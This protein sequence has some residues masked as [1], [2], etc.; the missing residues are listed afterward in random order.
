MK[1]AV[2][3]K[4]I[5]SP[6]ELRFD[7]QL[8]RIVRE[9]V[10]LEPNSLDMVALGAALAL[11]AEV[12]GE[13]VAVSMGPPSARDV[14]KAA[15]M[16]GADA[17]W[18]ISD[19]ALAGSDTLATAHALADALRPGGFDLVLLGR[20]SLDAET[21]QV[22]PMIA[23]LLGWSV[24][25]AVSSVAVA[26]GGLH[27]QRAVEDGQEE[28]DCALPAVIT[29][30]EEL[31]EEVYISRKKV[32]AAADP[33]IRLIGA[34]ELG[35][36]L[37]DYGQQGSP[38]RV[39]PLREERIERAGHQVVA[40]DQAKV[41]QELR[42]L[43]ANA[44]KPQAQPVSRGLPGELWVALPSLEGSGQQLARELLG[45]AYRLTSAAGGSVAAVTWGNLSAANRQLLAQAGASRIYIIA[46]ADSQPFHSR[47]ASVCLSEAISL[48]RPAAVLFPSTTY[49]REWAG[50]VAARLGL[51]LTGDAT[52]FRVADEGGLV[53]DK[54]SLGGLMVAPI[55]SR[56]RP[57]LATIRPGV[58]MP[59]AEPRQ[60]T[61]E[62]IQVAP[63]PVPA[64]MR[65]G[66]TTA[67]GIPA[68]L[69]APAS[70]VL[71]VGNGV[72]A[73]DIAEVQQVALA[74]GFALAASRVVTDAGHLPKAFQV[75]LTGRSVAPQVYVALGISGAFEHLVGIRRA[76]VVVAVN[77]DPDAPIFQA[78]DLGLVCDWRAGL[79]MLLEALSEIDG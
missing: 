78:C 31:A 36:T 76:A 46:V 41:H 75:G 34:Q 25:T 50:R 71:A 19:R 73:E 11:R 54:P 5:P 32:A 74:H 27:L 56:T 39:L 17:G 10:S 14:L 22:G 24:V 69:L 63:G 18:L 64:G 16:G 62:L 26:A 67:F 21:G 77:S 66:A 28:V 60:G 70:V 58:C 15:I 13:V 37:S 1:I 53:M 52:G 4:Q 49:G 59:L 29:A 45:D 33:P 2:C 68:S 8:R 43:V 23:E 38:T 65:V 55:V 47:Q 20:N 57:D 51:G 30:R 42:D 35:G 12:G 40:S 7:P 9:G 44:P 72:A 6:G 3:I 79:D 61:V 48:H